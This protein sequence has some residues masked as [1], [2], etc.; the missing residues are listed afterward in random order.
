M[1][2]GPALGEDASL[3]VGPES[4]WRLDHC[5]YASV[6]ANIAGP[7]VA[8]PTVVS[9]P[10]ADWPMT[11][12]LNGTCWAMRGAASSRCTGSEKF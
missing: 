10:T 5:F 7:P 1:A 9:I 3:Q 11:V 2:P 4:D 6:A 12:V 8:M